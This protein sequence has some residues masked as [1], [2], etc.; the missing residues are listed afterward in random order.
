MFARDVA[1][2]PAPPERFQPEEPMP[3]MNRPE[4][5]EEV[6]KEDVGASPEEAKAYFA[7]GVTYRF[8]LDHDDPLRRV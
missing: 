1:R 3:F 7:V 4:F 2:A 6:D 8:A 5:F